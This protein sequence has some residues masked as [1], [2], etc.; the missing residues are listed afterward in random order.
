MSK[1]GRDNFGS[2]RGFLPGFHHFGCFVFKHENK[3]ASEKSLN[4]FANI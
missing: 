2:G 3:D 4:V 1:L